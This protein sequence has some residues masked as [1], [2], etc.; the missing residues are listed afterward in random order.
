M[1]GVKIN[2]P[3][4]H[5]E[6]AA[7]QIFIYHIMDR[8]LLRSGDMHTCAAPTM[9]L[10]KTKVTAAMWVKKDITQ[11]GN[12][13]SLD[14]VYIVIVPATATQQFGVCVGL[15]ERENKF[16]NQHKERDDS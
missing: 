1:G 11:L 3:T 13:L 9:G 15:G 5:S 2:L 16:N 6:W 10:W 8:P 7:Q 14:S 4:P 12:L